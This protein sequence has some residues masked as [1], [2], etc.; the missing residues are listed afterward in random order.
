[1]SYDETNDRRY[2]FGMTTD[3]DF[4]Q[5]GVWSITTELWNP[6]VD[7]PGLPKDGGAAGAQ[8][9]GGGGGE[10]GPEARVA[11][12]RSLLKFQD[13]KYGGKMFLN[14]K[15][16]K[17]PEL[18]EGEVGGWVPR[19]SSNAWPGEPLLG[20]C[21]KHYRFEMFRAGLLPDV[22]VTDAKARLLYTTDSA[23]EATA[24]ADES[25]QVT[26]K[27]GASKGKYRIVEVTAV[28]ENKG[29]LATHT[30]RGSAL[31]GN[32][33][34]VV[35][36]VGARD[37][38]TFLQGTPYQR[39]G[40][41]DGAMRVPGAPAGRGGGPGGGM[42]AGTPGAPA[43][44]YTPTPPPQFQ[45]RGG[46]PGP[47]QVRTGGARREVRWLVAIEGDSPLKIVVSSQKGGTKAVDVKVQ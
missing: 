41:I 27:K 13:E 29:P 20:V 36:L 5:L 11:L 39:L 43:E 45:R 16:F 4:L 32:R 25:G 22:V 30:A 19:T 12:E 8:A 23:R 40:V 31:R 18:G 33:E 24:M 28:V 21:D 14:W 7:I 1:V 44:E 46:P 10:E 2:G 38:V 47:T 6:A 9:G 42:R 37:K 35:W 15:P 34:D 3:W 17:H 26:I